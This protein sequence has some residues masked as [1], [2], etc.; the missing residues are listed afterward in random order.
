M[1]IQI[2]PTENYL[3]LAANS[4]SSNE[5]NVNFHIT[6]FL[7]ITH[8]K[9]AQPEDCELFQDQLVY[10]FLGRRLLLIAAFRTFPTNGI[11]RFFSD[12]GMQ[13]KKLFTKNHGYILDASLNVFI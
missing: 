2:R 3:S 9:S 13:K 12:L 4:I 7:P 1:F 11:K 5:I 6:Y 10:I 8:E